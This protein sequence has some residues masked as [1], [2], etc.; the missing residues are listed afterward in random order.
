MTLFRPLLAA[1]LGV[2]LAAAPAIAQPA[3]ADDNATPAPA[4]SPDDAPPDEAAMEGVDENPGA[5][6]PVGE[7]ETAEPAAPPPRRIGYP[8]E[9]VLR[10]ITLPAVTSEVGIDVRANIDPNIGATL[11]ARYGITRQIQAGLRY[12]IGAAFDPDGDGGDG[13]SFKTGKAISVDVSYLVFDWLAAQVSVPIYLDPFAIGLVLGAPVKFHFA[14]KFALFAAQDVVELQLDGF[15]PSVTNEAANVAN[16][17]AL[18]TNTDTSDGTLRFSG[19][20]IFQLEPDL[21]IIGYLAA[22]LRDFKSQDL[23]YPIE[24]TVQKSLSSSFDIAGRLGFDDIGDGETFG[25]RLS[26]QLRI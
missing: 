13:V 5:P 23:G 16:A 14:D 12:G 4:P 15:V 7:E 18:D 3:D 22:E 8:I 10:P 11:R 26:A 17:A 2:A 20:A 25:V 24:V 1:W 21:A 9:E 6:R 19:G